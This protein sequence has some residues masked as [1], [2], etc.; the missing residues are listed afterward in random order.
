MMTQVR[1]C[2]P[3]FYLSLVYLWWSLNIS[4]SVEYSSNQ[5]W[6]NVIAYWI[7]NPQP[8]RNRTVLAFI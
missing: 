1:E 5:Y 3:G 2:G 4:L 7:D 6:S 8:I